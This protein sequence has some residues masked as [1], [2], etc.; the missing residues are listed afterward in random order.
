[1][2]RQVMPDGMLVRTLVVPQERA[3]ANLLVLNG[4]ADFL[5]KWAD[6]YAALG[7]AGFRVVSW[8]WRGQG[9]SGRMC[10]NGAGHIDSFDRWLEDFDLL[11]E[12]ALEGAP[13]LPW[14]AVG[15]SM[16][17][18]LLLRWLVSRPGHMLR[19][20]IRGAALVSPFFGLGMAW[21]LRVAVLRQARVE[22]M[23]GRGSEFAWGQKPYGALQQADG[24]MLL[25]TASRE[26]FLDE[27]RW[28]AAK[29]ELAVG[30]VSWGWLNGFAESEAALERENLEVF[31]LP[32]LML[33]GDR[34]R[35]VNAGAAQKLAKRLPLCETR[36][37]ASAAHELLREA[38][39][40]RQQSLSH[41][42]AFADRMLA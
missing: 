15:H 23:K 24:R 19:L 12:W 25:L 38:D 5:E 42:L 13:D 8:D 40:P 36:V 10:G 32:L 27:H 17:G 3:R 2:G 21:A 9:L 18:H 37:V 28:L 7:A 33:L 22:V 34:E 31:G 11:G 14:L 20:R 26:R 1:M 29:P 4:R 6:V 39:G 41:F 16:G 35:L 30:G